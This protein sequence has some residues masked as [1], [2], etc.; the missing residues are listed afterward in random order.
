MTITQSFNG[1]G[2]TTTPT[3][4]NLGVFWVFEIPLAWIL[5]NTLRMGPQGAF[6]A[7]TIA[8]S[9]LAVVSAL[10][11]RRGGWKSRVV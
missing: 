11:F 9:A 7:A 2:D 10:L 6:L 3:Y 8:F 1:A 4:I 5:A